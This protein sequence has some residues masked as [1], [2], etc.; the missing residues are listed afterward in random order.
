MTAKRFS[1]FAAATGGVVLGSVLWFMFRGIADAGI[2]GAPNGREPWWT[3]WSVWSSSGAAVFIVAE[4][5]RTVGRRRRAEAMERAAQFLGFNYEGTVNQDRLRPYLELPLFQKWRAAEN[6]MTGELG[7]LPVEA[8]DYTYREKGQGDSSDRDYQ[9]TVVLLS[10]GP[11]WPAFELIP[12]G[13]GV[14]LST[15]LWGMEGVTLE[16]EEGIQRPEY[17]AFHR[18]YF[19]NAGVAAPYA[20]FDTA[21]NSADAAKD[22][23]AVGQQEQGVRRLFSP[24]VVR[25]LAQQPRWRIQCDGRRLALWR[26]RRCVSPAALPALVRDAVEVRHTLGE[27]AEKAS[28][29][30]HS[31]KAT[32]EANAA[33]ATDPTLRRK[34]HALGAMIGVSLGF[35]TGGIAGMMAAGAIFLTLA[36][37]VGQESLLP[38]VLAAAVFFGGSIGGSLL[39][40]VVGGKR[41]APMIARILERGRSRLE[42]ANPARRTRQPHDSNA[43]FEEQKGACIIHLPPQGMRRAGGGFLFFWRLFWN[44]MVLLITAVFVPASRWR[45]RWNGTTGPKPLARCL[46]WYSSRRSGRLGS[47]CS[48]TWSIKVGAGRKL[49]LRERS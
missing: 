48:H 29:S 21:L 11:D 1:L 45:A 5:I 43:R 39:G 10:G 15:T 27:A 24:A 36:P 2:F 44:A 28:A 34:A 8:L 20:G 13:L 18:R 31:S 47:G 9:Q 14:Q 26:D 19:L 32:A 33:L 41:L 7:R 49:L 42:R 4:I 16:Y 17:D 22:A 25:F 37:R 40:G 46:P 30:V 3:W 6:Y 38:L 12:R 23:G 35:F